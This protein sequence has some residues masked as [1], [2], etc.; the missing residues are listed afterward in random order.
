MQKPTCTAVCQ[1]NYTVPQSVL[2]DTQYQSGPPD[3]VMQQ[4]A[5]ATMEKH[6]K[7]QTLDSVA[8]SGRIAAV[9]KAT[10]RLTDDIFRLNSVCK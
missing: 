9:E 8:F 3:T 10:S 1:P 5:D 2:R 7:K 4:D 6:T